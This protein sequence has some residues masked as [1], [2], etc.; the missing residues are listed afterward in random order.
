VAYAPRV[1]PEIVVSVL[2][3]EGEH[4]PDAGL[5]ARDIVKAYFD[6]RARRETSQGG[7]PAVT[8]MLRERTN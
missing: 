4:G 8:A 2:W 7:A 3:E 1:N 5:V 6:K